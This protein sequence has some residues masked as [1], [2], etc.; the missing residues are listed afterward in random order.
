MVEQQVEEREGL[1]LLLVV[2]VTESIVKSPV[3]EVCRLNMIR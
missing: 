1:V 2:V 3:P